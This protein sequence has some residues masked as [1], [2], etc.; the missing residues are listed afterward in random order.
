MSETSELPPLAAEMSAQALRAHLDALDKLIGSGFNSGVYPS[1]GPDYVCVYCYET[2][3]STH[4]PDFKG[5]TWKEAF[6]KAHAWAT[7]NL[8]S[9]REKR[10]LELAVAIML[11]KDEHGRVDVAMLHGRGFNA[12]EIA[13]L[14]GAA[15]VRAGMIAG[16][17]PYVVEGV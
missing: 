7:T 10:V 1:R 2:S 11:L 8:A 3:A 13:Q 17:A 12:A 5:P 4:P 14:H 6:E 9:R 16:R 15:C